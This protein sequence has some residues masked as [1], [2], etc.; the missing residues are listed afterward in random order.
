[1]TAVSWRRS[2]RQIGLYAA[3][4]LTG[5]AFGIPLLWMVST[6]VKTPDEVFRVPPTLLR[7]GHAR[8]LRGGPRPRLPAILLE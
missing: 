4:L 6:S 8:A 7:L 1:M 3:A 2:G 5:A